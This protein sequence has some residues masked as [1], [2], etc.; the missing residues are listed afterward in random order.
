VNWQREIEKWTRF[1]VFTIYGEDRFAHIEKIEKIA[2]TFSMNIVL[3]T[4][5]ILKKHML[6]YDYSSEH[7][8]FF[9]KF[10]W[11]VV[12]ADE[13]HRLKHTDTQITKA[14]KMLRRKHTLLITGTP[15]QVHIA[16]MFN[17]LSL[18]DPEKFSNSVELAERFGDLINEIQV[19]ELRELIS[20][21]VLRR[22]KEEVMPDTIAPKEEIVVELELTRVQKTLYRAIID[23]KAEFLRRQ[24]KCAHSIGAVITALKRCCNHPFLLSGVEDTLEQK[25]EDTSIEEV[26][27][28]CSS[29]LIFVDKL[30]DRV[31]K[32][33]EKVLIFCQMLDVMSILEDYLAYKEIQYER[34]DGSTSSNDRMAKIDRFNI[35]DTCKVFLLTTKAGGLGINLVAA[36]HVV[37]YDS[38]FNPYND[39]QAS[40]RC[41]R[42]GQTKKV[43]IYRL[44]AKDTYEKFIL[45]RASQ[46]LGLGEVVLGIQPEKD[47]AETR[48]Q[49]LKYGVYHFMLNDSCT[50]GDDL[51]NE[52]LDSILSRS[53][54]V[55]ASDRPEQVVSIFANTAPV[56]PTVIE[57][58]PI[59]A[60]YFDPTSDGIQLTDQEFWAKVLPGDYADAYTLVRRLDD[61]TPI[62]PLER[63]QFIKRLQI[64]I[65]DASYIEGAQSSHESLDLL[66]ETGSQ[67]D[68]Q[69]ELLQLRSQVYTILIKIINDGLHTLEFE[70]DMEFLEESLASYEARTLRRRKPDQISQVTAAMQK[71]KYKPRKPKVNGE[72][73]TPKPRTNRKRRAPPGTKKVCHYCRKSHSKCCGKRPCTNCVKKGLDCID[74]D[75][76]DDECY[77]CGKAGLLICCEKCPN[78]AHLECSGLDTEPE[79]EW[80][81]TS[82]FSEEEEE[83]DD[84]DEEDEVV[85]PTPSKIAKIEVEE[86]SD[87]ELVQQQQPEVITPPP[88]LTSPKR[89]TSKVQPDSSGKRRCVT[90]LSSESMILFSQV[91]ENAKDYTNIHFEDYAFVT[92]PQLKKV[93]GTWV[94]DNHM[95]IYEQ[96]N[97]DLRAFVTVP[98]TMKEKMIKQNPTMKSY[99]T[100]SAAFRAPNTAISRRD[101]LRI[102]KLY[103]NNFVVWAL[104]YKH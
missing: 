24:Y 65:K 61:P 46:R 50:S 29:K 76:N 17:L 93:V 20:P 95:H 48:E 75:K 42:I 13:A 16:E 98:M 92:N 94:R 69:Q 23:K 32:D 49:M 45:K 7:E 86:S 26:M 36:N 9:T 87:E 56:E 70:P 97:P 64:L 11:Q 10:N 6:Q 4:Y 60:M 37:I 35:D 101:D 21:H 79:G 39:Q 34:M 77:K 82:C 67:Y 8:N 15:F 103:T 53:T 25:H 28:Q 66:D 78:A 40:A 52:N 41:H 51:L 12:I 104:K 5:E 1:N 73:R 19:T 3:T 89:S 72:P 54:V 33:G 58:Q 57:A 96:E 63:E 27:V 38:D 30:L 90:K 88:V 85:N 99:L 68:I 31:I 62:S 14:F 43:F 74:P 2:E 55:K 102:L 18:V 80:L 22:T 44:I 84:D 81:C 71:R 100:N 91:A 83:E 47:N 59:S